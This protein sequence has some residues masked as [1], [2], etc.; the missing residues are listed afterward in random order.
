[1]TSDTLEVQKQLQTDLVRVISAQTRTVCGVIMS[2]L[3]AELGEYRASGTQS[4]V[5][6]VLTPLGVGSILI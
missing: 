4:S 6:I 5:S 1:M 2:G 3:D